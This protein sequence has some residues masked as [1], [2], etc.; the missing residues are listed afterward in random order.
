MCGIMGAVRI[1]K[2]RLTISTLKDMAR[3]Q[4]K[5][6]PHAWGVAWIDE[7]NR[8]HHYKASGKITEA[9]HIFDRMREASAVIVHT[10]YATHGSVDD[11]SNNHPHPSDGGWI[12]HNG[13]IPNYEDIL[14]RHEFLPVSE[15]DSE[16]LGLLIESHKGGLMSRVAKTINDVCDS[17]PLSM[18][19]LWNRPGRVIVAKRGNPL[20]ISYGTTGNIYFGTLPKGLPGTPRAVEDNTVYCIEIATGGVK[21]KKIRPHVPTAGGKQILGSNYFG[22]VDAGKHDTATPRR[23]SATANGGTGYQRPRYD[24]GQDVHTADAVIDGDPTQYLTHRTDAINELQDGGYTYEQAAILFA[25]EEKERAE[26]IHDGNEQARES[27]TDAQRSALAPLGHRT[28]GRLAPPR[29]APGRGRGAKRKS[30][31]EARK[32]RAKSRRLAQY[33]GPKVTKAPP[34]VVPKMGRARKRLADKGGAK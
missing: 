21:E 11:N 16:A 23:W 18:A 6:G 14:E 2:G 34:I 4:Q 32:A 28:G 8:L 17:V 22:A 29:V 20:S 10:R 5:R 30:K 33:N 24:A 3:T 1:G 15:C 12:I 27:L 25:E 13:Q 9:L 7:N 31:K 26:L 19:G